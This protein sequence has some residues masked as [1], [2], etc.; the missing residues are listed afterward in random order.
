[1]KTIAT[2]LILS[3]SLTNLYAQQDFIDGSIVQG[4]NATYTCKA[5][6]VMMKVKF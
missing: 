6:H 1:M 2:I 3:L 5:D 4:K